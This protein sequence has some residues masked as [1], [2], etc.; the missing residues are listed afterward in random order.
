M[1]E[2]SSL[3]YLNRPGAVILRYLVVGCD[4]NKLLLLVEVQP[5]GSVVL[6]LDDLRKFYF[7]LVHI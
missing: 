2:K 4:G 7:E 6:R 5:A 3:R 1:F